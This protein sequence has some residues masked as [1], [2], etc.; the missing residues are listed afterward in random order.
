[1]KTFKPLYEEDLLEYEQ[2]LAS[3]EYWDDLGAWWSSSSVEDKIIRMARFVIHNGKLKDVLERYK[4]GVDDI[5]SGRIRPCL[6][7][8]LGIMMVDGHINRRSPLY[9]ELDR[10][11]DEELTA[12]LSQKLK[13]RVKETEARDKDGKL[14][15]N[16][17][18]VKL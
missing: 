10:L 15:Y 11:S 3:Q 4:D 5:H 18:I 12:M 13:E 14:C 8:Y 6:F 9:A 7:I 2:M 17:E 1:M 16:Y